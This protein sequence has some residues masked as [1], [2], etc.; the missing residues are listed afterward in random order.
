MLRQSLMNK[1]AL[2][3]L[4]GLF[5]GLLSILLLW[6]S[7]LNASAFKDKPEKTSTSSSKS[8]VSKKKSG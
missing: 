3:A 7:P 6:P 8:K 2:R 5:G 1:P 4:V